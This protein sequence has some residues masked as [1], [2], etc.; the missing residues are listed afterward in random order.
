MST[1]ESTIAVS[2]HA[3]DFTWPAG[4]AIAP[5]AARRDRVTVL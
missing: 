1:P 3:T 2:A 5:A 4:G